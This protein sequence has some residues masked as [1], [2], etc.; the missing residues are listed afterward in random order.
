VIAAWAAAPNPD[1]E[2]RIK[3]A[4]VFNI[5]KFV[6]WP[7][8]ARPVPEN[9]L[10]ICLLGED[11][12]RGALEETLRDKQIGGRPVILRRYRDPDDIKGCSVLFLSQ[13]ERR[14]MQAIV[15]ALARTPTL[16]MAD[17]PGFAVRG[18]MVNLVFGG[19]RVNLEINIQ[20]VEKADLKISS[21]VLELASIVGK[22]D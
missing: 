4:M 15:K 19:G 14:R 21:Q 3:A 8:G 17:T 16:T 2:C 9:S 6:T 20:A 7:P 11:N 12:F 13:S 18:G 22:A 1:L 5:A 10:S